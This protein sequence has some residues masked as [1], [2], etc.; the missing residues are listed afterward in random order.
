[1]ATAQGTYTV[2]FD[3]L[4]HVTALDGDEAEIEKQLAE[5]RSQCPDDDPL[6]ACD[7]VR[8][9]GLTLTDET[10]DGDEIVWSGNAE[11]WIIGAGGKTYQYV[12][13]R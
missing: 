9:E 7:L 11:G 6:D 12:V 10:R 8:C 2:I 5:A 13:R 4:L 1:M 3:E